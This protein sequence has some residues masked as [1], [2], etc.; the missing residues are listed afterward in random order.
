[1]FFGV[2]NG[3][4]CYCGESYGK[5]GAVP[6]SSCD[7]PCTGDET[8]VCGASNI[9][10]V[11]ALPN[12]PEDR[13]I[14]KELNDDDSWSGGWVDDDDYENSS[15]NSMAGTNSTLGHYLGCFR[16]SP[17]SPLLDGLKLYDRWVRDHAYC[18]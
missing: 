2:Q 11:Y 16:D 4:K 1:M 12:I 6:Q 17:V 5:H 18:G 8:Q 15:T 14:E 9:N 10:G 7:E 3:R 13:A